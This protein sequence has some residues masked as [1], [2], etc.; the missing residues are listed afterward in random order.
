MAQAGNA[1]T[2]FKDA[3]AGP[4]VNWTE[5]DPVQRAIRFI[6]TYC[7]SPKGFGFGQPMKLAPFQ[8]EWIEDILAPGIRQAI[9]QCPRGQ[10]KSTLLAA[11]AVWAT[12]DIN[13]TGQPMVP[14]MATTVLQAKRAIFDV[15]TAMITA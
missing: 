8:V 2:R 9:L 10:G 12:F 6:T 13:I 4:W 15:A 5:T 3:T 14:I 7:R 11:L 1:R